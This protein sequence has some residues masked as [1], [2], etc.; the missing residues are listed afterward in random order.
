[1]IR[2]GG[3]ASACSAS[4]DRKKP[5]RIERIVLPRSSIANGFDNASLPGSTTP[6]CTRVYPAVKRNL[7]FGPHPLQRR[8][9]LAPRGAVERIILGAMGA[10]RR[11]QSRNPPDQRREKGHVTCKTRSKT[12]R[13]RTSQLAGAG[14]GNR[15]LVCSLG[16]CRSTIELRP[17]AG[18]LHSRDRAIRQAVDCRR[19][20]ARRS[21]LR[22]S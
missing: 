18:L 8:R 6:L 3:L 16:S 2:H 21:I 17:R 15:T 20:P 14:E 4:R 7:H 5:S 12:E 11:N 22:H 10:G 13:A 1:M 19:R 9:E